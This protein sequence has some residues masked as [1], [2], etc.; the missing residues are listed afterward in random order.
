MTAR[1]PKASGARLRE[2]AELRRARASSGCA[3]GSAAAPRSTAGTRAPVAP[4]STVG[5][6]ILPVPPA[7][8]P[9]LPDRGLVKGSVVSYSGAGTLLAGLLAAVTGPGGHAAAVGLPR[10]GLLAAAEMGARLDR[11]AVIPDAGQDPMEVAA[12]L[13]DGMDLV[14]L[15]LGTAVIPPARAR[16]LAAKARGKGATLLVTGGNWPT[17]DLSLE[18]RVAGYTGLGTGS[19]RIRSISL[20][21]EARARAGNPRRGR[22]TARPLGGRVEWIALDEIATAHTSGRPETSSQE[23]SVAS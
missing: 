12:V 22:L 14:V 17:P 20:D 18:S 3:R 5:R 23:D 2:L 1:P 11:L 10:L 16:V 4:A 6:E 7:L 9:L 15:G 8:A 19:G 21:I 13:L